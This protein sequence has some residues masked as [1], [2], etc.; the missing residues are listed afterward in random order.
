MNKKQILID[1]LELSLDLELYIRQLLEP[2]NYNQWI[3]DVLLVMDNKEIKTAF[4]DMR[5]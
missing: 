3:K 4:P 1:Y 2:E 5:V